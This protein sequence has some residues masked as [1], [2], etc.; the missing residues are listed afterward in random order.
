MLLLPQDI[1]SRLGKRWRFFGCA[2][3]SAR[4][5]A[6]IYSA[7]TFFL[8]WIKVQSRAAALL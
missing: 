2:G 1:F 7:W 6:V 3:R 5:L 4:F 8:I